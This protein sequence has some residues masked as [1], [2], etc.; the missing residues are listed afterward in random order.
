[1]AGWLT[2][3]AAAFRG[4]QEAAPESFRLAC[5]CGGMIAGLR[6]ATHQKVPCPECKNLVLVLPANPYPVV[7]RT[8]P[9][10]PQQKPKTVEPPEQRTSPDRPGPATRRAPVAAEPSTKMRPSASPGK[11]A[12][13][14]PSQPADA[15]DGRIDLSPVLQQG[16]QR[17]R[18][19]RLIVVSI[20]ALVIV[21]GWSLRNR[22]QREQARLLIPQATEEG[23][24]ALHDGNFSEAARQLNVAVQGLD[25]LRR[26]DP[27]AQAIRQAQREAAAAYGLS[28]TDLSELA[29]EFLAD[30]AADRQRRFQARAGAKWLIFD[31]GVIRKASADSAFFELDVP[32]AVGER[33]LQV[34]GDF[35]ELSRFAAEASAEAP[36]HV[37]FAGQIEEWLVPSAQSQPIV[38]RLR[39]STAF[40]WCDYES[41]L[42]VGY[43]ADSAE[44]ERETRDL[45]SRQRQAY[46]P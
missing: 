12:A 16:K 33:P 8:A 46:L 38:V 15:A 3:A 31:A 21:T 30:T 43:R 24:K 42:A 36:L 22:S 45:L 9:R 25:K 2:R 26:T 19:I 37:V 32:F 35:P 28:T 5:E 27:A 39:S 13:G 10:P 29:S 18:I 44:S 20:V 17:R 34:Q 11:A 23:M 14:A 41:L 4:K 1:M 6:T 7:K 40:L